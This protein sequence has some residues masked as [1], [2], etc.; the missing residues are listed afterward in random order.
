MKEYNTALNLCEELDEIIPPCYKENMNF[1]R[2]ILHQILTKKSII[3]ISEKNENE[4]NYFEVFSSENRLCS[5]FPPIVIELENMK[6]L[7]NFLLE[8]LVKFDKIKET[9]LSFCL[10]KPEPPLLSINIDL[11]LF[12]KI[13][14]F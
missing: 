1:L 10:P 5:I 7:V 3:Q 12:E 8:I 4:S 6:N 13:K 14:V 9:R 2:M 11:S